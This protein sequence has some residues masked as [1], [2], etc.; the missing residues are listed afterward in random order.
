M[1]KLAMHF[2]QYESCYV[3]IVPAPLPVHEIYD[4]NTREVWSVF[5][6]ILRLNIRVLFRY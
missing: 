2:R 3:I 6:V 5:F 1:V 4:R